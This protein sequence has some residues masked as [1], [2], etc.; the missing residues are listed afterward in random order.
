MLANLLNDLPEF[1]RYQRSMGVLHQDLLALRPADLLLVFVGERRVFHA[2][3][4]A[5]IG[6]ILQDICHCLAAPAIRA[7]RVQV[8]AD[9]P[10]NL[11][12]L[13][14][15]VQD[16]LSGQD[17]GDLVG[18]FPGGAQFEDP[19]YHRSSRLVRYD[20]F[21]L[22]VLFPVAVGRFGAKS[23][24]AFRLHLFDGTYL[25][26]GVLGVELVGPVSDRVEVVAALHQ[27]VHT[28]I[29]RDKPDALLREVELR[30]LAHLQVFPPQ[31]AEILDDQGFHLAVL[32]HLHDLL[33]R[34]PVEVGPGV[35]VVGQKQSVVKSIFSC[36]SLEKELLESDLSRVFSP[37]YITLYQKPK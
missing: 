4:V 30:Q 35:T 6:N 17:P 2:E 32:N 18:P 8:V 16:L 23:F 26:A 12:V 3:R 25:F 9:C 27:G 36:I 10:G 15:R 29:D 37:R 19:A 1:L 20:F 34:G 13:V 14:G 7:G 31:A 33:P 21:G 28:V 22:C 24:P 5:K 11:V